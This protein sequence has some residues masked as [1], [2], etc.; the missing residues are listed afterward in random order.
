MPGGAALLCGPSAVGRRSAASLVAY[1][2][3][4]E[5]VSPRMGRW[6]SSG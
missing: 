4:L 1:M 3:G 5:L 6:G 2:H